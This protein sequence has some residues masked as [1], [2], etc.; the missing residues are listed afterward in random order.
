MVTSDL[1]GA[2]GWDA[3]NHSIDPLRAGRLWSHGPLACL[4]A[5]ERPG[6]EFRAFSL[7]L[8]APSDCSSAKEPNR[9]GRRRV[10]PAGRPGA[11]PVPDELVAPDGATLGTLAQVVASIWST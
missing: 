10:H 6:G 3:R 11:A 7:I 1:R 2:G 9:P 5:L 8:C 4:T